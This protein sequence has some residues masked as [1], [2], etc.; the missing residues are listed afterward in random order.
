MAKREAYARGAA[1]SKDGQVECH[2]GMEIREGDDV[3]LLTHW[4]QMWAQRALDRWGGNHLEL[5]RHVEEAILES[6]PGRAYFVETEEDGRGVQV[7][8]PFGMPRE[9][10]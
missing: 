7:Y 9:D 5:C 4:L 6:F 1:I 3:D 2:P 8:Q 10:R